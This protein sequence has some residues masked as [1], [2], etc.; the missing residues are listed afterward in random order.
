[1]VFVLAS[2]QR[3]NVGNRICKRAT[4]G[5]RIIVNVRYVV[6]ALASSQRENVG[7]RICKRAT[8][9]LRVICKRA[10]TLEIVFVNVRHMLWTLN[11]Y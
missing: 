7:N 9:G 5:L 1:M 6:A 2:S 8:Y 11:F 10:K 4:Y 3:E